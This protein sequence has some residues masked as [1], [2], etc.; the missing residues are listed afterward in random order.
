VSDPSEPPVS[1]GW[2]AAHVLALSGL[3]VTEPLLSVLGQNPTFFVAHGS[4]PGQVLLVALLAAVVVPAVLIPV[5]LVVGRLRPAWAWPLHLGIVGALAA[6][7]AAGLLDDLIGTVLDDLPLVSGPVTLLAAGGAAYG[8]VRAYRHRPMLRSMLSALALA[9]LGFLAWFAFATPAHD[10]VFPSSVAAADVTLGPDLPPIV[11]V[12]FDELPLASLVTADAGSIDADRFP[13]LARLAGDGVWYPNATSVAGYTHE[14][15]P[16]ILT[17]NR[18]HDENLPPTP[19]GHPDSLFTFLADDYTITSHEEL[20]GL[21]TPSLCEESTGLAEEASF[22]VLLEDLG[23]VAGHVTLPAALEGWLPTINDTWAN[24]GQD[25]V[26]LDQEADEL[27]EDRAEFVDDLGQF[28]RVGEFR[29]AVAG[30]E[31]TPEPHLTFIHSVFPHVPWNRHADGSTYL[32][33]GN[34]GLDDNVWS[35]AAAGDLALQRHLLQAEFADELLGELLDQL[36]SEGI[37][38]DALVVFTADHGASFAPGTHRRLPAEENIAGVMPVP[39]VV[40]PPA[41]AVATVHTDDRIAEIVDLVPTIADL[42]GAD[43]PWEADGV[44]LVGAEPATHERGIYARGETVSTDEDPVDLSP[45][46]DHTWARFGIEGELQLYGFGPEADRI[47]R[48]V[49][50]VD[51]GP[52]D[53]EACWSSAEPVA[54]TR[55]WAGGQVRADLAGDLDLAVV[56]DDRVVATTTTFATDERP[57]A[58]FALGDPALWPEDA[59]ATLWRITDEGWFELPGC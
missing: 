21:C 47:G 44:S 31:A 39:M 15:V 19:S 58:V 40:K 6:L 51:L 56:V 13:N 48:R 57:H 16:A 41:S 42:L 36:E 37:Y 10:L 45:V 22:S 53:E 59:P 29:S 8:F 20:T 14:A 1:A 25:P 49:R 54:G 7:V 52:E 18:V 3:A 5:E 2:R 23:I 34:P 55:A 33:P 9:P 30:I 32:D 38:D 26:A 50:A 11:M 17:G 12:V 46:V 28:D 35:T 4:G 43:L 24:F 27:A